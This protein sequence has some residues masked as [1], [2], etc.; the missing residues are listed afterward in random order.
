M[1][2]ERDSRRRGEPGRAAARLKE[3]ARVILVGGGG[4]S[5]G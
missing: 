4:V 1:A 5:R 3:T 2:R